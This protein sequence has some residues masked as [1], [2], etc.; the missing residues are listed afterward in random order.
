MFHGTLITD[1]IADVDR[2]EAK[3][4]RRKP[5]KNNL[6]YF[7]ESDRMAQMAEMTPPRPSF[8]RALWHGSLKYLLAV[9]VGYGLVIALWLTVLVLRLFGA[10][11]RNPF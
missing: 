2:A 6:L 10:N 7:P 9:V 11:V 8:L 5:V 1:L 4:R 3:V